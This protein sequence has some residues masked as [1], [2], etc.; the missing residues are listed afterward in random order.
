MSL[1]DFLSTYKKLFAVILKLY[2]FWHSAD[3]KPH[4]KLSSACNTV[5]VHAFSLSML[6]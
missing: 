6:Q 3:V 1:L 5:A 2:S 4:A